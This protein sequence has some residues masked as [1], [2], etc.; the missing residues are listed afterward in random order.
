M[1]A[2][3]SRLADS[4]SPVRPRHRPGHAVRRD[5]PPHRRT[6]PPAG[7][8]PHRHRRPCTRA[9]RHLPP[10]S[11]RPRRQPP[12]RAQ[13]HPPPQHP[14]PLRAKMFRPASTPATAPAAKP[15]STA[16]SS[17]A[18]ASRPGQPDP[19]ASARPSSRPTSGPAPGPCP[20]TPS[21]RPPH[22][23]SAPTTSPP[24]PPPTPTLH[25][26]PRADRTQR[27]APT[28]THPRP[29]PSESTPSRPSPSPNRS[30]R[31]DLLIYRVTAT[32]FL[33][34]MVRNLVGTFVQS[35]RLARTLRP[36]PLLAARNRSAAGPTAPARG[37]FLLKS[38]ITQ[39]MNDP[40][41]AN[42]RT[43]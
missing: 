20:S 18:S 32:G 40:N 1:T 13:P 24:S 28:T 37:L 4:V 34:H 2:P 21:T 12:P 10:R 26:R 23:S 43:H 27:D 17:A 5:P 19:S 41:S 6:G 36:H 38:S 25:S 30:R 9:G 39:T 29:S 31:D 33:H 42:L 8:R 11:P 7:L 16:S 22:S 14:R 15:T 35:A 3:L